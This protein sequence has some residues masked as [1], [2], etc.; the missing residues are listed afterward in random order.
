[1]REDC[2]KGLA[3]DKNRRT[4][5][6]TEENKKSYGW[7]CMCRKSMGEKSWRA[8]DSEFLVCWGR[9]KKKKKRKRKKEGDFAED[10]FLV[11]SL[12][13]E[14]PL[15]RVRKVYEAVIRT[16]KDGKSELWEKKDFRR[17]KQYC[18]RWSSATAEYRIP[19]FTKSR[20][21]TIGGLEESDRK[22][23]C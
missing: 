14:D 17:R 19:Y 16:E 4:R 9:E 12:R 20:V 23:E 10:L 3:R 22:E 8:S 18:R 11:K 21:E 1:M 13:E 6:R 7:E 15:V 5:K 2:T